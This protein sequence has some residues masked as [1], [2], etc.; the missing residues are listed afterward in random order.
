MK[1]RLKKKK[2]H[3]NPMQCS[4]ELDTSLSKFN[5]CSHLGAQLGKN[6]YGLEV[7]EIINENKPRTVCNYDLNFYF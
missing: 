6:G 4:P 7:D 3:H 1:K 5:N 2:K